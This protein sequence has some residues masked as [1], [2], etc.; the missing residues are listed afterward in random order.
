MV[1]TAVSTEATRLTKARASEL[2]AA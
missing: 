1:A 2:R